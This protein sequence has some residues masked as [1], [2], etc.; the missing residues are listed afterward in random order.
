[1]DVSKRVRI[2]VI[3][4][5]YPPMRAGESSNAH[6]LCRHLADR[7]LDVQVL[8]SV[9]NTGAND[10][11]VT[12]H[13]IMDNWSWLEAARLARFVERCSPDAVLLMYLDA[14]YN[15]HPMMTF[16][17]TIAKRRLPRVP[18][19][20]RYESP[21]GGAGSKAGV[22]ARMG[23][24]L[25]A[26]LLGGTDVAYSSG[27]LLR[28]SDGVIV[29][30]ESHR[31]VLVEEWPGVREKAIV[32]PP[33]PNVLICPEADGAARSRGRARLGIGNEEFV[34]AFF[35]YVYPKKGIETLLEA[36]Q[37]LVRGGRNARLVFI[38]G[39]IDIDAEVSGRYWD[40]MQELCKDLGVADKTTWTGAFRSD[41]EEGSLFLRAADVCV[42]PLLG[43]VQLNNSSFS[44]MAAHGMPIITTRGP[45]TDP[46]FVD[47]ENVR[48][49]EPRN[50][51]ALAD[52]IGA[53]IDSEQARERLR[54]GISKLA[55]E[56]LSWDQGIARTV[57]A[58]NVRVGA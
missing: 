37:I 54:S 44:V 35:G 4:G 15:Y 38:G 25:V 53:L 40:R 26:M 9:G 57:A 39:T 17:A 19:V 3:S 20:T 34:I 18:F 5:A 24:K 45:T 1:M 16:A 50:A 43:G 23:R 56:W 10:P 11:G 33:S 48:F 47:G 52:R 14:M 51:A 27:T 28:D 49:C 32:I 46:V 8:T 55:H 29:L 2:L 12:V 42:L 58:L 7:K 41:G 21:L 22:A 30:C 31:M 13:P 36:F 6:H